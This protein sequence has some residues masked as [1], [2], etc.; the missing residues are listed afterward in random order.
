MKVQCTDFLGIPLEIGDLVIYGSSDR[1]SC[2]LSSG[3]VTNI[4][5]INILITAS[6]SGRLIHRDSKNVQNVNAIKEMN[7][8]FFI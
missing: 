2:A 4:N 7:P 8:E 1:K 5:K 6:I 3:I